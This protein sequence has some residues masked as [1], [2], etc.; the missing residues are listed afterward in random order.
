[1]AATWERL[2]VERTELIARRSEVA[3][4]DERQEERAFL[5]VGDLPASLI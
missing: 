5:A 3:I 2:A 4:E 1:M